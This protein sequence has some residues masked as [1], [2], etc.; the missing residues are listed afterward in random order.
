VKRSEGWTEFAEDRGYWGSGRFCRRRRS[1]GGIEDFAD[2]EVGFKGGE[3][4]RFGSFEEYGAEVSKG[5]VIGCRDGAAARVADCAWCGR[6]T[7]MSFAATV[8]TEPVR[9]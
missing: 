3:D 9:P 1:A 2:D 6:R 5:V 4:V 7:V 8:R